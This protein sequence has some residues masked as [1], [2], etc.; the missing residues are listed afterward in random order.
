MGSSL[1]HLG[2]VLSLT[3][4][5]APSLAGAATA[6][7]LMSDH[8]HGDEPGHHDLH[9][10][11]A[12]L[13]GHGHDD[14]TPEHSHD[15]TLTVTSPSQAPLLSSAI[16]PSAALGTAAFA[17]DAAVLDRPGPAPP[18]RIPIVLRI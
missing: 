15:A 16:Y 7:H 2:C 10:A 1:R 13:H 5:L 9:D 6:M 14:G 12:T 18:L 11:S 17:T 4:L 3:V 8:S